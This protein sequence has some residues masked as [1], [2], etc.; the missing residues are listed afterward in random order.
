M[1]NDAPRLSLLDELDARQNELLDQLDELDRRI[2]QVL[3]E[4]LTWRG[5]GDNAARAAA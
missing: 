4:C 5:E 2:Q 1:T 3:H